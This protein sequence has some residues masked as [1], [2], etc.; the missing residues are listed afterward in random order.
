MV[1]LSDL[2]SFAT[3]EFTRDATLAYILEWSQPR[4]S[5][6]HPRLHQ[7][8]TTM[9][10]ALLDNLHNWGNIGCM[11]DD[12]RVSP[13]ENIMSEYASCPAESLKHR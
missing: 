9:L 12:V 1:K 4:Y 7:L 13:A 2:Y 10:Y 3:N 5:E 8:G 11:N 6:T